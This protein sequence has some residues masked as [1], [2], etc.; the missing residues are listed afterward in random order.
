MVST[1]GLLELNVTTIKIGP[2]LEFFAEAEKFSVAPT[3]SDSLLAERLMEAGGVG[4]AG[5][6]LVPQPARPP[7]SNPRMNANRTELHLP[8]HPPRPR[9]TYGSETRVVLEN[10]QCRGS[11]SFQ[12]ESDQL[13]SLVSQST[14]NGRQAALMSLMRAGPFDDV[15]LKLL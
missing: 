2:P 1:A 8:M 3:S 12:Q 13:T 9:V 10:F 4:E 6:L 5:V 14:L 15:R 11:E 7:T